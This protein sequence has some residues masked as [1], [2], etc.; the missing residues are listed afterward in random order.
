MGTYRLT[1]LWELSILYMC[2]LYRKRFL[3]ITTINTPKQEASW[4]FGIMRQKKQSGKILKK[5][6]HYMDLLVLLEIIESFLT[7]K[8]ISTDLL[9]K[10]IM[11]WRLYIFDSLEHI[12]NMTK[13]M[14]RKYDGL[15]I[16]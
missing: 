4:K 16:N 9:Y 2:M 11:K 8:E 15:Q 12:E 3:L 1:I 13:S 14:R 10:L 6:K 7:L 5:S